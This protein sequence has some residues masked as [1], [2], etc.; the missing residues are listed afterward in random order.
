[1][2][3]LKENTTS[4][5]IL[6]KDTTD[7]SVTRPLDHICLLLQQSN[8]KCVKQ[9]RQEKFPNGLYPVY[10][11]ATRPIQE[12]NVQT[13]DITISDETEDNCRDTV[14]MYGKGILA[15]EGPELALE[16]SN[17]MVH[18]GIAKD[19]DMTEVRPVQEGLKVSIV[20]EQDRMD[21]FSSVEVVKV[22]LGR[23]DT[24]CHTEEFNAG[25]SDSAI[26]QNVKVQDEDEVFIGSLT[27]SDLVY[28]QDN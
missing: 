12:S 15:C 21:S 2:I 25:E 17:K 5:G 6:D 16:H 23:V 20:S 28:V 14:D 13:E 9:K 11:I 24:V 7:S 26:I 3:V 10:M 27:V 18:T 8:L 4:S 19:S 22:G 1:M